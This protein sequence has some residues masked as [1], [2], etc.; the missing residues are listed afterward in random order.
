MKLTSGFKLVFISEI[1][2]EARG[3]GRLSQRGQ[4]SAS[5]C[6]WPK[7]VVDDVVV[8]VEV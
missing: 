1:D 8:V 5:F 7:V 3:G 4:F 2:R 6:F